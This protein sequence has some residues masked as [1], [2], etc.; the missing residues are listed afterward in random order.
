[1][2]DME[3]N[4]QTLD[5]VPTEQISGRRRFLGKGVKAA[6]FIVT[7]ASQPALGATCFTPSRSLSKNTSL[8]QTNLIGECT[9]AKSPD[10]YKTAAWP[11]AVP[12]TTPMHTIFYKGGVQDVS[13]FTRKVN[14]VW[15]S[16][17]M[18]DALNVYV[19]SNVHS[20][21]IAAY[22]NKI[23]GAGISDKAITLDG[24]KNMWREFAKNGYFSP[25]SGVQWGGTEI[26]NYLKSNGIVA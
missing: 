14:N 12:S 3:N 16:K 10:Y 18:I 13:K 25:T 15:V 5:A 6:P 23:S 17:T 9:G 24:I 20:Y 22:L 26:V 21:L 11:T 4:K 2:T 1:M 7:L 19:S 8:S